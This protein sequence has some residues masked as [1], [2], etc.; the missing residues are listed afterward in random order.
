MAKVPDPV[1]RDKHDG[2]FTHTPRPLPEWHPEP[3]PEPRPQPRPEPNPDKEK[4]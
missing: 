4:K 3:R 1:H 2:T